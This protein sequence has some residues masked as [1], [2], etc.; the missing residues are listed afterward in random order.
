VRC[1]RREYLDTS[2]ADADEA[3]DDDDDE[4]EGE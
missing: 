2:A 4:E 1:A 3:G